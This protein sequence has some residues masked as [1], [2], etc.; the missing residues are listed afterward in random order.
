MPAKSEAQ[1]R[2]MQA[3][4][5]DPDVRKRTG[6]SM[7]VASEFTQSKPDD[8]PERKAKSGAIRNRMKMRY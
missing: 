8:L 1:Y 4:K 5:H 2:L 7:K 6:I 3:A